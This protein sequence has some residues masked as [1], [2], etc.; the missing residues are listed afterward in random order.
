MEPT[1]LMVGEGAM[2][3]RVG[4]L[5]RHRPVGECR[6]LPGDRIL[7]EGTTLKRFSHFPT[8]NS[9]LSNAP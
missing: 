6:Q 7:W 3:L 9:F 5:S 1:D 8:I 2:R 4:R